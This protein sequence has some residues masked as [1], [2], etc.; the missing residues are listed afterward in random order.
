MFIVDS[1]GGARI[2][3]VPEDYKPVKEG[4]KIISYAD[5]VRGKQLANL[6]QMTGNQGN[7]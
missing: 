7:G 5:A 2:T 4:S 1:K 6:R 3:N